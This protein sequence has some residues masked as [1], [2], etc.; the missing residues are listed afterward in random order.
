MSAI[1]FLYTK[2]LR[3]T[4]TFALAI[5]GGVFIFERVFDQGADNLFEY[6]N[7]GVSS[8]MKFYEFSSLLNV[9]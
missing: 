3:R 8:V 4:S 9:K 2:V 1:N 5:L 6:M 7:R